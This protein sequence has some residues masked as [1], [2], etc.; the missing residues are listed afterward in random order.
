MF[1]SQGAKNSILSIYHTWVYYNFLLEFSYTIISLLSGN[2]HTYWI[3]DL[4]SEELSIYMGFIVKVAFENARG[5]F[6]WSRAGW[7]TLFDQGYLRVVG[8]WAPSLRT[9]P[10]DSC[11]C[12]CIWEWRVAF[13]RDAKLYA[14]SPHSHL[15]SQQ[16]Y[17]PNHY[18]E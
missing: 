11:S 4:E 9:K 10:C 6:I 2:G 8:L 12:I 15:A 16:Y 17:V 3:W 1:A 14:S 13:I 5:A 18:D 7:T